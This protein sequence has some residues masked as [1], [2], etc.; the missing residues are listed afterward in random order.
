MARLLAV[1]LGT[2]RIGLA[3]SDPMKMIASPFR[4]LKYKTEKRLLDELLQIITEKDVDTVIIGLP[5][6]EDGTEGHGCVRSRQFSNRL[7]ARGIKTVLWDERY[8]SRNA[9]TLL[10]QGG[11]NRK[12]AIDKIDRIAASYILE[13]YMTAIGLKGDWQCC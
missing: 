4:T 8:S 2:R 7:Q 12:K 10:R 3:I 6:R 9:E 1:D 11:L 5:L 13:D